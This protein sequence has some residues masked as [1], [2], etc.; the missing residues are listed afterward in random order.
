MRHPLRVVRGRA[1]LECLKHA[2]ESW[3]LEALKQSAP[4]ALRYIPPQ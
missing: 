2:R 4:Y 1:I 3:A